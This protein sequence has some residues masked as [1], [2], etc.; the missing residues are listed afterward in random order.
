MIKATRIAVAAVFGVAASLPAFA[1]FDN[2][3]PSDKQGQHI[4]QS[5]NETNPPAV[6][7]GPAIV[8][9]NRVGD[10]YYYQGADG[11][12]YERDARVYPD[13]PVVDNRDFLQDPSGR[14]YERSGARADRD[15]TVANRPLTS[16]RD[17]VVADNRAPVV[18][19]NRA[20]REGRFH[21]FF[22]RDHTMSSSFGR[23]AYSGVVEPGSVYNWE[24]SVD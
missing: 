4:M 9:D 8:A 20:P 10:R 12:M 2:N 24:R 14:I 16:D 17:Y 22:H 3:G 7:S 18:G 5:L 15:R 6:N 21:H 19:D 11:R 13:Q 1:D 23:P